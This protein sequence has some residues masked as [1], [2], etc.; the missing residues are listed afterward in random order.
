[1]SASGDGVP[2]AWST[3]STCTVRQSDPPLDSVYAIMVPSSENEVD[4][5]ATVP[6]EDRVLGSSRTVGSPSG[7]GCV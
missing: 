5:R 1:L 7:D 6:S 2:S 3:R 4:P